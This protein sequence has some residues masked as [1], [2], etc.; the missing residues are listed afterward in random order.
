[1]RWNM[2]MKAAEAGIWKS[3]ELRR[4]LADAGLE[5][6]AGK[7][8]GW[9]TG[10][11]TTIRLDDL[12]VICSVLE[13]HAHRPADLR[14]RSS[15]SPQARAE[16]SGRSTRGQEDHAT[17]AAR[18][19]SEQTARVSKP[20]MCQDCGLKP[21]AYHGRRFCYDCKPGT[22]GRPLPCRRCGATGDYWTERLCRRCHQHAPQLPD[23]CRDCLAW[24]ATRTLKWLCAACVG[25]RHRNREVSECISCRRELSLNE[26]KACRLCWLQTFH[27]QAQAGLPRDVL[28]ANPG[29]QQLWL[30]NMVGYRNGYTPHP[31]RD[32]S[33][34]TDQ[35]HPPGHDP[36]FDQAAQEHARP[37]PAVD[38]DQLDLFAYDRVEDTARRFGFGEPPSIRFAE[39]ARPARGRPR[40]TARLDGAPNRPDPDHSAGP[41]GPAPHH[42]R[43]DQGQRRARPEGP[44]A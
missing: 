4:Q 9:W 26:H 44:R 32:Y 14:A 28:A 11:P 3:T 31:R 34:P 43:S 41:A 40:R 21:Q 2:R 27:Y 10:T 42:R 29:S 15:R 1:M 5:I 17:P 16:A 39:H 30:A 8:S 6:S 25:W 36:R 38:P 13:L 35:I 12:D 33:R 20:Q 37:Q 7:M 19:D 22:N 18:A 23:S 24:G